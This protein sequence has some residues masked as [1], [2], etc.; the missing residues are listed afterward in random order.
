MN[1]PEAEYLAPYIRSFFEDHLS[2]RCNMSRNTIRSYRDALKLLLR[3]VSGQAKK[4]SVSLLVSDVT[5]AVI[6]A[7]LTDLE[8]TR[9]NSIQTRNHRL[10]GIRRLFQYIAEREP[11]LLDHCRKVVAVPKKRGAP[12]PEIRY[13]EKEQITALLDAVSRDGPLGRRDYT[14]LL[15]MYNT[16]ARVQEAADTRVSWLTLTAPYKVELLGKGRKWRSCPLWEST[17]GQVRQLIQERGLKP[18]QEGHLFVNR[19]GEPLSR[20]GI[21]EIVGRYAS[22]AATTTPGLQG[23][24]VTPHTLRHTTAMH[25]LQSG[26]E[27]NVIRSWLGHASIVTTNR[28]IEIDLAMK[29]KA[30]A[31]C[32]VTASD[33]TTASWCSNPDILSWLDSL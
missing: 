4:A 7:F 11:L 5:E 6:V 3:F 14:L 16:G 31:T 26:V 1:K 23:R 10:A 30:L 20:S 13:L 24:K 21:A 25:L 15:F 17:V 27:V 2:C 9:G 12:L 18:G 19:S 32:E 33:P 22:K 8:Q 28:Y 29:R